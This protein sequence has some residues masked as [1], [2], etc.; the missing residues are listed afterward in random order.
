MFEYLKMWRKTPDFTGS[1]NVFDS[2]YGIITWL[3][4]QV[5]G[6]A[7]RFLDLFGMGI[8]KKW[9]SGEK[10]QILLMAYSGARNTGAEVRVAELIDQLN[11]VLGEENVDL[12]MLTL[13]LEE[14]KEYFKNNRV[15]LCPMS[16]VFFWDVFKNVVKNQVIVLVEGSCWKENFAAALL[17]YFVYGMGLAAKLGKT[18][19]CYGVDAGPMNKFNSFMSWALCRKMDMIITR[20]AE[21]SE[22]VEKINLHVNSLRVDTAWTLRTKPLEWGAL[23]LKKLGWDGKKPLLGLAMQNFFWWPIIPD[24]VRWVRGVKEYQYRLLYYYDYDEDDR[25]Q[26]DSWKQTMAETLDWVAEKYNAQ[27]VLIGMEAL[28][29]DSCLD[30]KK[31]M[32]T[33]PLIVSCR[34]YVGVEIGAMLRNLTTLVTTRYHAMVLAMPGNTPFIGLSRDERIRGVMKET[35]LFD[36]Y[37]IDYKV[38]DLKNVLQAKIDKLLS[39]ES[40]RKRVSTVIFNTLPYYFAQM[41]L[42]GLDVRSLI[43]RKFPELKIRVLNEDNPSELDPFIPENLKS[44]SIKKFQE[45]KAQE[46]KSH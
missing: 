23:E 9:K 29:H 36:E 12:N 31:L 2:I 19:F 13:N 27:P 21:A 10:L 6:Y 39:N 35:G 24:F 40:E 22:W 34:E 7:V 8:N 20:S 14:T 28:D 17:Y 44:A 1:G 32:K 42:L 16:Y 3:L 41:A 4:V 45:L 25:K 26:Y 18:S 33:N 38:P 5:F 37:Y 43:K 30:V 11:Q 15:N 46:S